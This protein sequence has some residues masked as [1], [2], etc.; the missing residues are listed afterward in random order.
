MNKDTTNNSEEKSKKKKKRR[1][2]K[3]EKRQR[4]PKKSRNIISNPILSC[5][6]KLSK[7]NSD[8]V[9]IFKI[10]QQQKTCDVTSSAPRWNESIESNRDQTI[11]FVFPFIPVRFKF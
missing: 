5:A 10:Q 1:W 3:E 2:T 4:I 6:E 11:L 7:S 9:R 8:C